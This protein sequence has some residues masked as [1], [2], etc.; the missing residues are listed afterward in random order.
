[1]N[2]IGFYGY[3]LWLWLWCH[4]FLCWSGVG[5]GWV[6][7][8]DDDVLPFSVGAI[9]TWREEYYYRGIVGAIFEMLQAAAARC[10]NEIQ[11]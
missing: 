5:G 7:V 11:P 3:G 2:E 6:V 8:G 4:L 9:S 1:M 10:W